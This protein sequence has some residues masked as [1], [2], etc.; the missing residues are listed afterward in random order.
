MTMRE[1]EVQIRMNDGVHLDASVCTPEGTKP[2]NGYPGILLVHG[3]GDAGSKAS[4]IGQGRRFAERGYL[5]VC[6]S[7]RGQGSSEG[8]TFHMGP[9]ELFD[10]QDVIT[11]ILQEQPVDPERLGVVGSSQGGWHAHMAAAHDSRIA[12]AVPQNIF[13]QYD[14][15]A[16]HNGCLTKW[17]FNRTMRRRIMS[18]GFQDLVRRWAVEGRWDLIREWVRPRSPLIFAER[19]RCPVLIVHGW[20]DVGMPPNE[21]LELYNRLAVPKK[22]YLGGGGHDGED[23]PAAGTLRQDLIDRWLDHWLMGDANGIMDEPAITY[24]RRPGWEHGTVSDL[25][26]GDVEE[27]LY[28]HPEG[29][30]LDSKPG[31]PDT[32]GNVNNVLMKDGYDLGSAIADQME[33]VPAALA[34]ES[35]TF[36]SDPVTDAKEILGSPVAQLHM[37]VN[38]PSLQVVVDLVDSSPKGEERLITRGHFGTRSADPGRHMV[39]EIEMRTIGYVLPEG[40]RLFLRVSNYDTTYAFPYFE[41]FCARLYHGAK[42]SSSVRIPIRRDR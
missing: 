12:T 13:T 39:V 15:F 40:H 20:H 3:H 2:D 5:T 10:L 11:W 27:K 21:V 37:L 38:G 42:R 25:P 16:V 36:Q 23:N 7:V 29:K 4:T 41:P 24:A 33:G 17:F 1:K 31:G 19:V 32:H 35:T 26:P 8:L 22:L 9:R 30:L 34:H 6:Y 28:L 18:A 14:E